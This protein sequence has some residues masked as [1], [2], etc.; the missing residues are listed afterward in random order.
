[1]GEK[2]LFLPQ[3]QTPLKVLSIHVAMSGLGSEIP[4]IHPVKSLRNG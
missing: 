1:M 2:D 3:F 4:S